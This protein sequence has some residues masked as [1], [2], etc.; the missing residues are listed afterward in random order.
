MDS[1]K[2]RVVLMALAAALIAAPASATTITA[3]AGG[4]TVDSFDTTTVGTSADPWVLNETMTGP[5]MVAFT[6]EV[7]GESALIDNPTGSGHSF[8]KWLAKTIINNS[9]IAWTSFEL[10]LRVDPA[11]PSLDGDGLSFAQ[12]SGFE[13]TFASDKFG[14]YSAI[15][16]IRDYLN[17]HNGIVMPGES[18]TFF[19]AITDNVTREQFFLLQV[20]NRREVGTEVPEPASM[21]LLGAGLLGASARKLRKNRA[22]K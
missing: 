1:L 17:F 10:E 16:D 13:G 21:L 2:G 5:G 12:G 14:T 3:A 18:V 11:L 20:P 6:S 4:V 15:E 9:G 19:F 8:G 7:A 22:Q